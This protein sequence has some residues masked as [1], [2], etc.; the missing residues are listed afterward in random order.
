MT[1]DNLILKLGL[2]QI[3][4]ALN[5]LKETSKTQED[6]HIIL[7]FERE[8]NPDAYL[9][10]SLNDNDIQF[11]CNDSFKYFMKELDK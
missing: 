1:F 4:A 3:E 9:R 2:V 5:I 6:P 8:N 11:R 7:T 10:I